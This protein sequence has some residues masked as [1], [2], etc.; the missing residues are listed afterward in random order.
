MRSTRDV[1]STVIASILLIPFNISAHHSVNAFFDLSDP[2]TVE[3]T[4]T[5]VWWAN[6]HVHLQ[7]ERT[8]PDGTAEVWEIESGGPTLLRRVGVTTDVVKVG[9]RVTI[10]GYPSTRNEN[11][12]I[13]VIMQLADG[14]EM[15][16][17]ATLASRF[18]QQVRS[19]VHI[20]EDAAAAGE[21]NARGIFRVWS[22]GRG[23]N[24]ANPEP[25]FTPAAL[26]GR[27]TYNPLTDD[28]ALQ[29]IPQ[30]MPNVMDNPFPIEF[31]Q[32]D[33]TLVLRLEIWDIART[34]I[35][36]AAA[37]GWVRTPRPLGYSTG[38]WEGNT[39]VVE[40]TDIDFRYFDDDGTPQSPA[41]E[42]VERFTLNEDETR[43]DYE[44]VMT[45]PATLME[46]SVRY[47]HWAWVPGEELQAYDC[48]LE[49]ED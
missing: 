47:G 7:M 35:M 33:D 49:E 16:M 31:V 3:G 41:M 22:F 44:A 37:T 11:E 25:V 29:C 34:I 42:V 14:R 15:T 38:H 23:P 18:G 9:E 19:G 26:A 46:P 8:A 1:C 2:I 30:G 32:R 28:L 6:P 39:L 4:L 13:G 10:S 5:S 20:T 43:L 45:D 27:E 40:T 24:Q 21:Q 48:T 12:M 36:D 17:F